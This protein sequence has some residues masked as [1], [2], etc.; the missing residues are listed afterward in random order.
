MRGE[1]G[2]AL[3]ITLLVT[4]LLVALTVE[5]TTEVFVDT[6]ARHNFVAGQQASLL[7][8]SGITGGI[9]LLQRNLNNQSYSSLSDQWAQ[10]LKLSDER[11][12]LQL[13]IE[14]ESGKL[15]LNYVAPPSGELEGSFTGAATGRLL[16][17]LKIEEG[18]DLLDA[19]ADWIDSNDYPHPGGA[20]TDYY[21]SLSPPYAA[22][23][24]RLDTLDELAL[25]KGF[26][27][28]NMA[29]VRR[30]VTVY[31]DIPSAPTAPVNINT[32]QKE[33]IVA[34]DDRIS[35]DLAQRVIDYRSA[36]PF[37]SPAE[38]AKV[39]GFETIATGL[40]TNMSVKGNVFRLLAEGRVQDVS[41]TI[42]TVVRLGGSKPQFLY[43]REY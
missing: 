1:Q 29:T 24:G 34:L 33:V 35:D 11:G 30:Y 40:L 39:P 36:T 23:N 9:R 6:S 21:S 19:L 13:S 18:R 5:F 20:E 32:A 28:G 27:G 4:A 26:P 37:K 17:S 43:W 42:E 38:L 31:P 7:A 25:V 12:E 14:E 16:R 22:R 3:I 10:Q 8:E 15:N 2:F 41:R